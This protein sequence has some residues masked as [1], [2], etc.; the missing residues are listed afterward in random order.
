MG[1][2]E[3]TVR[4]L[5]KLGGCLGGGVAILAIIGVVIWLFSTGCVCLVNLCLKLSLSFGGITG[6]GLFSR[7]LP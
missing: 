7:S 1:A 2:A 4:G 5:G 3:D 6:D